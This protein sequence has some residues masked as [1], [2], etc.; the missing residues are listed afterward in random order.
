MNISDSQIF[1]KSV[2][3]DAVWQRDFQSVTKSQS[4]YGFKTLVV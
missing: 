4:V 2:Q 3:R 1:V